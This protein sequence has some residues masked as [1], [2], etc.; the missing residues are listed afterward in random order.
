MAHVRAQEERL[1]LEP[2]D[3]EVSNQNRRTVDSSQE[4]PS[5]IDSLNLEVVTEGPV[6]QHLE[7]GVVISI[8]TCTENREWLVGDL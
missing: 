3:R 4:L 7:E 1:A 5:H 6:A 8:L 2:V